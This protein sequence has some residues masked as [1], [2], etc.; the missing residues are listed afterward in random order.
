VSATRA[1]REVMLVKLGGSLITDKR[2]PGSLRDEVLERLAGELAAGLPLARQR[3][4]GVV[5]GHGSGSFG[6]VAA[7]ESGFAGGPPNAEQAAAVSR[8]QAR[9]AELHR[10]V[11]EALLAAGLSPYSI[12]PSSALTLASGEPAAFSRRLLSWALDRGLLPVLYGDVAPDLDDGVAICSTETALRAA[13][14][15]L[16]H[17]GSRVR[18][19]LWLGETAGL[20]DEAGETIPELDPRQR[21][22]AGAAAGTDVTGGMEHRLRSCRE[23]AR[24]GVP[25]LLADGTVSGLLESALRGEPIAGTRIPAG[26]EP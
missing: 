17:E 24:R 20:L 13:E 7:A 5:L 16:G 15:V 21:W 11:V 19:A 10:H 4:V 2:R 22:K 14:L 18:L 25:S 9:A 8:T 12:A 6:H 26:G 23:L 3:G 1:I